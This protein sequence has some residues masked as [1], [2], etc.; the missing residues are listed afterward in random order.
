MLTLL[1]GI[2]GSPDAS[3]ASVAFPDQFLDGS[4]PN[5]SVLVIR[6][7]APATPTSVKHS[8]LGS[9]H[10]PNSVAAI[11]EA[12]EI[13]GENAGVSVIGFEATGIPASPL[14]VGHTPVLTYGANFGAN[15]PSDDKAQPASAVEDDELKPG[16]PS[17]ELS[18]PNPFRRTESNKRAPKDASGSVQAGKPLLQKI[19]DGVSKLALSV[20]TVVLALFGL[21]AIVNLT[22]FFT[23]RRFERRAA[24]NSFEEFG[25]SMITTMEVAGTE[26]LERAIASALTIAMATLT[27]E[28]M[29]ERSGVSNVLQSASNLILSSDGGAL[30]LDL[31]TGAESAHLARFREVLWSL[32]HVVHD[33]G[34][35][36][37]LFMVN[38][39]TGAFVELSKDPGAANELYWLLSIE[40]GLGRGAN[41]SAFPV[42]YEMVAE[43]GVVDYAAPVGRLEVRPDRLPGFSQAAWHASGEVLWTGQMFPTSSWRTH[44]EGPA[45][46]GS[47]A[48]YALTPLYRNGVFEGVL[49]GGI[50]MPDVGLLLRAAVGENGVQ[51]FIFEGGGPNEGQ[52]VAASHGRSD[53]ANATAAT[54]SDAS[55][56]S[57]GAELLREFGSW[58]GVADNASLR[59]ELRWPDGRHHRTF[60][61]HTSRLDMGAGYP[62][63]AVVFLDEEPYLAASRALVTRDISQISHIIHDLEEDFS[64]DNWWGYSSIILQVVLLAWLWYLLQ[65]LLVRP[66]SFLSQQMKAMEGLATQPRR[67]SNNYSRFKEVRHMEDTFENMAVVLSAF[68]KFVPKVVVKRIVA[69]E[70]H[71]MQL[72][73]FPVVVTIMFTD[74][75]NFTTISEKIPL[76]LLM[77]VLEDYLSEMSSL[78]EAS[79]G[80]IGDFIGDGIMAFW[81]SPQPVPNH[82]LM[83]VETMERQLERLVT[84]NSRWATSKVPPVWPRYGIHVGKVYSGNIGSQE[85][86]K[87]GIV[88]DPVNLAARLESLCKHFGARNL[89]SQGVYETLRSQFVCFL[90]GKVA[91]K[92]KS[93]PVMVYEVLCRRD[94]ATPTHVEMCDRMEACFVHVEE[95][96]YESALEA[97]SQVTVHQ[98][99]LF[100]EAKAS[101]LKVMDAI[102]QSLVE[103]AVNWDGIEKM[104]VK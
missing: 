49:G 13:L 3:S 91:V 24:S 47:Y 28:L 23:L 103:G 76:Q 51:A 37:T 99:S 4:N 7:S 70:D 92:G 5:D 50:H 86:M 41:G 100:G 85:K 43:T 95:Q 64:S 30:T 15:S 27:R 2:P 22:L 74:I 42:V 53:I 45:Q 26:G 69:R 18:I 72:Y 12:Q 17:M 65:A 36:P 96:D 87:F 31:A 10:S 62:W 78:I 54:W 38:N 84:L 9:P 68:G 104:D 33:L 39:T 57:L 60:L 101:T 11:L 77:R 16:R 83:A 46:A 6:T 29:A 1:P 73:V 63:M 80:V 79:G 71:A 21:V 52:L 66:M 34:L 75:A 61:A 59:Y 20:S 81:N 48:L 25:L 32:Q 44:L 19:R 94:V 40:D 55:T 58:A 88:G 14:A 102:K 56:S 35:A 8:Q 90:H 82:E 97:V 98:Q 93:L 67:T 89:L